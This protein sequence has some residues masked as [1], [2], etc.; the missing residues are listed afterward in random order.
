[1]SQWTFEEG[2]D[3]VKALRRVLAEVSYEVGLAGSVLMRGESDKDL[4]IIIFPKCT[5]DTPTV[6]V[7]KFALVKFGMR[8]VCDREIV[9]EHW[10]EKGSLDEKHVEVWHYN[11]KRVDV[12]FMR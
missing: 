9:T 8:L 6:D 1:V 5:H 3:L 2:I 12:F 10:R 11:G 7:A 4:D